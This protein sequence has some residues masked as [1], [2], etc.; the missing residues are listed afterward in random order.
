[1][2]ATPECLALAKQFEGCRLEAYAD[3]VGVPTIG[4]GHTKG[5][6]M[7]DAC[8]Q[9]QAD[10]WLAEDMQSS[11]D[12]VMRL[13]RV[14][15]SAGQFAALCDF[16]FNLGQGNL[17]GST[18]LKHVNAGEMGL[19]ALEFPKWN[20]AGGVELAGLTRRRLAEQAMFRS[21]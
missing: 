13:V 21:C 6:R 2:Q 8:T 7:G 1:M 19:A 3:S 11:V 5:V 17:A 4:C 10:E 15:L 12:A 14:N 18:L 20:H 9:A 16:V